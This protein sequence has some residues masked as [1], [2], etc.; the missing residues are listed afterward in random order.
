MLI[1]EHGR[2]YIIYL[3]IHIYMYVCM[4]VCICAAVCLF[5]FVRMYILVFICIIMSIYIYICVCMYVCMYE[6]NVSICRYVTIAAKE[7][8]T[9]LSQ[10]LQSGVFLH[11][12][13]VM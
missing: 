4:Y 2:V 5:I 7:P 6:Y 13:L 9:F 12:W 1:V 8:G 3:C 10:T 11:E